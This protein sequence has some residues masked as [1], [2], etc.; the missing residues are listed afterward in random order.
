M[1]ATYKLI[2]S[3]VLG[4]AAATVAFSS[5]PNTYTDL[6]FKITARSNATNAGIYDT[7][8]FFDGTTFSN[9]QLLGTG[10]ANTS[11]RTTGSQSTGGA[12]WTPN[13]NS[14]ANT[15]SNIDVYWP[16]Y[17]STVNKQIRISTAVETNASGGALVESALLWQSTSA[18]TSVTLFCGNGSFVSGSSFYL[19]GILNS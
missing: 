16:N 18:L 13:A 17:N 12:I 7:G 8:Y 5:I 11:S 1:A 4:T 2:S 6:V 14:T 9:T 19:Y 3:N 15:F 10:A